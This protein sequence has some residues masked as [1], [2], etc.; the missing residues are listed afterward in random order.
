MGAE[1][2][3]LVVEVEVGGGVIQNGGLVDVDIQTVSG[4]HLKG[5]LYAGGREVLPRPAAALMGILV[6]TANFRQ[7]RLVIGIFLRVVVTGNPPC[8]MVACHR[9]LCQLLF[10]PKIDER[11]EFPILNFHREFVAEAEPVVVEPEADLHHGGFRLGGAV[12]AF[13]AAGGLF[14]G[15]EQF[16]VVVADVCLLSPHGF[17][18]L[19]ERAVLL[20]FEDEGVGEVIAPFEG[21]AH[22][23]G[24]HHG[25]VGAVEGVVGHAVAQLKT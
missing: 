19:I 1:H 17:P 14:K 21:E 7:L 20:V 25:L 2:K 5:G 23:G 6:Q 18:C 16:V 4:F 3:L 10:N 11:I 24:Q 15:Y 8:G 9:K 13:H 12:H 22:L